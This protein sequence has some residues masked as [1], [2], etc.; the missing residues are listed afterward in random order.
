LD[1]LYPLYY[2]AH[3][4]QG[5]TAMTFHEPYPQDDVPAFAES[6]QEYISAEFLY[7]AITE[8]TGLEYGETVDPE[9]AW[10]EMDALYQSLT[11]LPFTKFT[12][13]PD[14]VAANPPQE[15]VYAESKGSNDALD[16]WLRGEG[17]ER[18]DIL[19]ADAREHIRSARAALDLAFT[20]DAD[21]SAAEQLLEQ[22][23]EHLLLAEN[24]DGRGFEPHPSRKI[25]VESP[26]V[27]ASDAARTA[28]R[29]VRFP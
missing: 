13:I 7:F 8:R 21:T 1:L 29:A 2:S 11:E 28:V 9:P 4:E 19:E 6:A 18:L 14:Y 26:A 23:C 22:A 25:C 24:S 15:S 5:K 27:A 12:T 16:R 10:R 17:R 20:A 3:V